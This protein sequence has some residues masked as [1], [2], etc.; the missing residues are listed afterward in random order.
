MDTRYSLPRRRFV[1]GAGLVGLGLLAGCGRRPGQAQEPPRVPRLGI[2]AQSTSETQTFLDPFRQGL[3]ELGYVEGQNIAL[4]FRW[5]GGVPE[6]LPELA[7]ELVQAQVDVIV[8][9]P[10]ASPVHAAKNATSRIPIVMLGSPNPVQSGLIASLARPG[11]NITG[12][13]GDLGPEMVGKRLQLLKETVPGVSRA[14]VL[15]N[16]AEPGQ[17]ESVAA[18][19]EA[20]R[21]LGVELQIVVAGDPDDL[22]SAF[23]TIARNQ[24]EAIL[25]PPTSLFFQYRSRIEALALQ[26]RLP[27][28]ATTPDQVKAGGLMAYGPNRGDINRRAAYYV[29]RILK[30]A[31]PPD[32]PVE[33]PTTFDFVINLQTAQALGLTIPQ[34]VLLQATEVIQ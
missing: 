28:I 13:T 21:A 25:I 3:R 30:G 7:A 10:P 33:Q 26:L 20:A 4:D 31:K 2:L 14:A 32:L 19:A 8:T 5:A 12:V 15:R 6:R 11:G 24:T 1:Q 23:E 27:T 16:P 9:A 29:D 22:D 18:T 17:E 34:H